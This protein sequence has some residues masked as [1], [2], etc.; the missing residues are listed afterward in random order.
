MAQEEPLPGHKWTGD[1]TVKSKIDR[2]PSVLEERPC[3]VDCQKDV[4]FIPTVATPAIIER[5]NEGLSEG[6]PSFEVEYAEILL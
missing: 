1:K 3:D 4:S 2:Q 6:M 5:N